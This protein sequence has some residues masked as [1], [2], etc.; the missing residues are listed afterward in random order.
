MRTV[1]D[2][3]E[4]IV[5]LAA[6]AT[7][8]MEYASKRPKSAAMQRAVLELMCAVGQ[9]SV[10]EVCYYTGASAATVRR[11]AELGYL[12]LSQRSVLRCSEIKPARLDGPLV[13]NEEQSEAF[14]GLRQQM[15]SE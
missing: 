4:Q 6:S 5:T 1:A 7:E 14:S 15:D 2:K 10:K 13:L 9:S 3:T 8:A 12:E 11:L